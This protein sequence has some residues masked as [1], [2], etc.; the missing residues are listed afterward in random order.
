MSRL[1]GHYIYIL[2]SLEKH[3]ACL[4]KD[5]EGISV[6]NKV[7]ARALRQERAVPGQKTG[8]TGCTSESSG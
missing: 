8:V 2:V 4:Y 6:K 7:C 5:K 1:C 3:N